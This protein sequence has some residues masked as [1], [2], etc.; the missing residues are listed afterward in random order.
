M[1]HSL[2]F[3]WV[4]QN[5][6]YMVGV[7]VLQT[8][9]G[10]IEFCVKAP[11]ELVDKHPIV[12]SPGFTDS[13][14]G[15]DRLTNFYA[16]QGLI[17]VS[18]SHPR[19]YHPEYEDD[20][21]GHKADNIKCVIEALDDKRLKK[22]GKKIIDFDT[23]DLEGHSEGAANGSR[24]AVENPELV[25]TFISVA[26]GG[27]IKNDTQLKIALRA[28][29]NPV[30][31][32]RHAVHLLS[33]PGHDMRMGQRT[34]DYLLSNPKKA[35]EEAAKIS[36]A[37]IRGRY[38]ILSRQ[39]AIPTGALQFLSD[40]L[41]PYKLVYKDTDEGSIFDLFQVYDDRKAGHLTPQFHPR[42]V[43]AQLLDMTARLV[44]VSELKQVA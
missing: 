6:T 12:V 16:E 41:F 20:P 32:F 43:G 2:E 4:N 3:D 39:K 14:Y 44:R 42:K 38:I 19:E 1:S 22:Y 34:F 9:G 30:A 10:E 33:H 25:R 36:T 35:F 40:E 11:Q 15:T 7:G 27:L 24:F 26:G 37:D 18:F 8:A 23:V 13:R 28:A 31:G 17:G 29:S 5:E 21:E